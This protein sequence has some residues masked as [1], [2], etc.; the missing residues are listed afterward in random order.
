MFGQSSGRA[1]L[2][3][4]NA[5][6]TRFENGLEGLMHYI[7]TI[8][9]LG[10]NCI[11]LNPIFYAGPSWVDKYGAYLFSSCYAM[12]SMSL[13]DPRVLPDN[14]A[15]QQY[16]Q[17]I[18]LL[19][20]EFKAKW[21]RNNYR[22]GDL[23][24]VEVRD[25]LV[26]LR[27]IEQKYSDIFKPII[28]QLVQVAHQNNLT[29]IGDLVMNHVSSLQVVFTE[30]KIEKYLS[31][32]RS[33]PDVFKINYGD[34]M[35]MDRPA[36]DAVIA[37]WKMF[38]NTQFLELG[39]DGFRVDAARL[40]PNTLLDE[41]YAFVRK[42]RPGAILFEEVLF[43]DKSQQMQAQSFESRKILPTA[44]TG[45]VYYYYFEKTGARL[46]SFGQVQDGS[47]RDKYAVI[48]DES[49][50]KSK[51]SQSGTVNFV[52][53]HDHTSFIGKLT[54]S[55][56]GTDE[57]KKEMWLATYAA[58]ALSGAGGSY[59]L[60]GDEWGFETTPRPFISENGVPVFTRDIAKET[61]IV[62]AELI[63]NGMSITPAQGFYQNHI[64]LIH[65]IMDKLHQPVK[66]DKKASDEINWIRPV[67]LPKL[68]LLIMT[69]RYGADTS[70]KTDIVV[71]DLLPESARELHWGQI[72]SL[73][74]LRPLSDIN[75]K[76]LEEV[77]LH[78][79]GVAP[80]KKDVYSTVEYSIGDTGAVKIVEH[81]VGLAA[82][83]TSTAAAATMTPPSDIRLIRDAASLHGIF[84]RSEQAQ[85]TEQ[86]VTPQKT[87]TS[88]KKL[89]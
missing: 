24:L 49:Y 31:L 23:K 62:D 70:G 73:F 9:A 72:A 80:P 63:R 84:T 52:G 66:G 65:A 39:F 38:V 85:Q 55:N 41:I 3:I 34:L 1:P 44:V 5:F 13:I 82:S 71:I 22:L 53:N 67:Y 17:D 57:K 36:Y 27:A 89:Q 87:E 2:K 48:D 26:K 78:L 75:L 60:A 83:Q 54:K 61:K 19:E 68:N 14:E 6:P 30:E 79:Y 40:L 25:Y 20:E 21:S 15:F 29:I 12:S 11:W 50:W 58:I 88:E 74:D 51:Y 64:R 46:A 37:K 76:K 16:K 32:D 4:Y 10:F 69:R 86:S 59:L 18:K 43:S 7:P 45:S 81:Q 77:T 56:Y 42:V 33:F 28:A 8:S 47:F 35:R